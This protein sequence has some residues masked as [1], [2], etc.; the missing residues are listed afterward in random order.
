M[1][2]AFCVA[3][4]ALA[5]AACA[6]PDPPSSCAAPLRPAV[7]VDLY[8]GRDTPKGELGEAEWAAFLAEEV[9]PRFP[10]GLSVL[11]VSGQYREPS[12]RIV[13]EK[14]K[15]L[16][17]VVLDAPAHRPKVRAVAD[18]YSARHGQHGVFHTERSVC[19][20]V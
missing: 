15:L 10:D 20:G 8:F 7:Q 19:A 17:I 9:T 6:R 4:S 11:D 14:S 2:A 13:R 12:G 16:V 18:A 5:L 1:R 3:A